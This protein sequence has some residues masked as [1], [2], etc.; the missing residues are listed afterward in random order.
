MRRYSR[1]RPVRVPGGLGEQDG[2]LPAKSSGENGSG[3]DQLLQ[4]S[5]NWGGVQTKPLPTLS[6]SGFVHSSQRKRQNAGTASTSTAHSFAMCAESRRQ[7]SFRRGTPSAQG[8]KAQSPK[9]YG[10]TGY[11]AHA[12]S[13]KAR[14]ICK[15]WRQG[16][17]STCTGCTTGL[18]KH[19]DR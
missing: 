8:L 7:L 15:W 3:A 2:N 16:R 10:L 11:A 12:I 17:P 14:R 5:G 6:R 4:Q 1:L 13:V 18:R 19:P 9:R